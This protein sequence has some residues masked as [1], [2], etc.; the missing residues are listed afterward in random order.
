ML[1]AL[2]AWQCIYPSLVYSNEEDYS[3]SSSSC[4]KKNKKQ[5][6]PDLRSNL[7]NLIIEISATASCCCSPVGVNI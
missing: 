3:S 6:I 5:W 7:R 2:S 4:T 1:R